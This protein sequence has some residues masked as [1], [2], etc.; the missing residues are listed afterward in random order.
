MSKVLSYLLI[1]FL[2]F[3]IFSHC[4]TSMFGNLVE[5][6][7]G[8]IEKEDKEYIDPGLQQDTLYLSKI[9]A[10]N[11][12][13]LKERI[14][15]LGNLRT[16]VAELDTTVQSNAAAIQGLNT[17]MQNVGTQSIPDQ[18]TTQDLANSQPMTEKF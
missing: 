10:A 12:S 17:A 11:I 18:Q 3:L 14:D 13:Y 8:S 1:L 7:T 15:E 16:K 2:F 6:A 5:G 4:I 9:N